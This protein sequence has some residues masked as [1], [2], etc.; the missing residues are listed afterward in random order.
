MRYLVIGLGI[1]GTNLAK[2]LTDMGHEVIGADIRPT[3]V[4]TVK[5]YISTAY[6]LDS[7]DETAISV[8][9]LKNVDLVI[10]SIG[11]NFGASIKTVALL[12]K[13]GVRRIYARAIDSL[14]HAILEGLKVDRIL[15]PEQRAAHDLVNELELGTRVETL[16]IDNDRYVMR[17]IAPPYLFTMKYAEITPESF[18]GLQLLAAA[19][20]RKATNVIGLTSP[21][22]AAIEISA[23]SSERVAEGDVLTCMGTT[24]NYRALFR[25]L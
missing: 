18:Y 5:D 14:H 22:I 24:K 21:E 7:T 20:P 12:R 19:R 2:D 15:N 17:F 13:L 23:N 6:I 16:R 8:L 4:D 1:Y 3:N 11:E 10:V 9:P 25:H